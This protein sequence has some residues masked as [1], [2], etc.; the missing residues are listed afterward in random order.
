VT[1][2]KST[3]GAPWRVTR[4]GHSGSSMT[5]SI[6][7]CCRGAGDWAIATDLNRHPVKLI[8]VRVALGLYDLVIPFNLICARRSAF[9]HGSKNRRVWD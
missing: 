5:S 9:R 7:T 3:V 8:D 4:G 6:P 2:Q 1:D